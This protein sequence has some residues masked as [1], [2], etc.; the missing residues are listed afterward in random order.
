MTI[1]PDNHNIPS[2]DFTIAVYGN[3]AMYHNVNK[4][5]TL[6]AGTPIVQENI[7]R[8]AEI[9]ADKKDTMQELEWEG[10]MPRNVLYCNAKKRKVIFYTEPKMQLLNFADNLPIQTAV[11]PIPYLVWHVTNQTLDLYATMEKPTAQDTHLFQAPFLNIS[12]NGDVCMGTAKLE[13]CQTFEEIIQDAQH[14]FFDS[15]FTHSNED[16]LAKRSIVDIYAEQLQT[17][18][19]SFDFTMLQPTDKKLHQLI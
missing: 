18:A 4:D 5:G 6:A 8:F 1:T 11:Y 17:K 16:V 15:N 14:K 3:L 7:H 19:K 9:L 10:I 13:D 2:L 12:G